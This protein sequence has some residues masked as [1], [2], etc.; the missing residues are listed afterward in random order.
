MKTD[1][2]GRKLLDNGTYI[3]VSLSTDKTAMIN[4]GL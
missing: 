4:F 1:Y 2:N 3:F